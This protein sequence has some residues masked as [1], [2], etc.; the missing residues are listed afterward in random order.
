MLL[1]P[2]IGGKKLAKLGFEANCTAN[3]VEVGE[4]KWNA[5]KTDMIMLGIRDNYGNDGN[6]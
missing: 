4:A 6:I 2:R 5:N 1:L 3:S